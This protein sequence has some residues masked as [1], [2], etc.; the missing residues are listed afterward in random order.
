MYQVLILSGGTAVWAVLIV[1]A[2]ITLWVFLLRGPIGR[3]IDRST[4]VSV[5]A[6][7]TEVMVSGTA[8]QWSP[9]EPQ[10]PP[11]DQPPAG[12]LGAEKPTERAPA[13]PE[14]SDDW[15]LTMIVAISSGD[16]EKGEE[17][18]QTL[19]RL[20]PDPVREMRNEALYLFLRSMHAGD[21]G[22]LH[23]LRALAERKEISAYAQSLIGEIYEKAGDPDRAAMAYD[24]AARACSTE[25]GRALQIVSLARCLSKAGKP[26]DALRTLGRALA[27]VASPD[28][29]SMLYEGFAWHYEECGDS[30]L[31]AIA[32]EKAVE[33]KPNE[34]EIR[35]K[36]GYSY[37]QKGLDALA[38]LHYKTLLEFGPG[39]ARAL[40][41]IGVQYDR[42]GL[43]IRAVR[44]YKKAC[45][46]RETLAMAN[47]AYQ[48]MNAG[49]ADEAS[50]VLHEAR[51]K[52]EV[53]PNVGQAISELSERDERESA[54]EER[55]LQVA[56]EQQSFFR[57]FAEAYFVHREDCPSLSGTWRFPDGVEATLTQAEQDIE[58]QWCRENR[59]HKFVGLICNR[60]AR[61]T[62]QRPRSA[63]SRPI[64][65]P[66]FEDYGRGYAYLSDDG[67]R[68]LMMNVE[69]GT[70]SFTELSR[71][72]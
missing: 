48:F 20:E 54:A 31:R 58:A 15:T 39:E 32:L 47:L 26:D 17:A 16:L 5:K 13:G 57:S 59:K 63:L 23:K 44:S 24:S 49:F 36:A 3:L 56:R 50:R 60:A 71:A 40:N 61:I 45:E 22:A 21:A 14:T 2:F 4:S 67:Q 64:E 69:G 51:E 19:Q 1:C 35:F 65:E 38:L 66:R 52:A 25:R 28:V 53:H 68:L 11:K 9:P 34:T 27:D 70:H 37:S 12:A 29:A 42:F 41:N 30:E 55:H 18:F 46:L 72:D 33:A 8:P 43:P 10:P 6:G 62:N 7:K